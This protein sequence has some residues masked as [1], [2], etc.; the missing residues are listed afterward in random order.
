MEAVTLSLAVFPSFLTLTLHL[1]LS[2]TVFLFT[3]P[4]RKLVPCGSE[5]SVLLVPAHQH[6]THSKHLMSALAHSIPHYVLLILL[7]NLGQLNLLPWK[8]SK[9]LA[10]R[11]FKGF[12]WTSM[13]NGFQWISIGFQWIAM[14]FN[15]FSK[16]FNGF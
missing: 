4:L 14:N 1:S 16:D 3:I 13:D 12:Q 11:N 6:T 5:L 15:G 2:T 8:P 10:L 7:E 9:S